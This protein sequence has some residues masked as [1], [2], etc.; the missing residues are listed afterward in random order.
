MTVDYIP[1]LLDDLLRR[2]PGVIADVVGVDLGR[3]IFRGEETPPEL[4]ERHGWNMSKNGNMSAL[5][6]FKPTS[7]P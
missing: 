2:N 5:A 7:R 3:Y 1:I 4:M 6:T